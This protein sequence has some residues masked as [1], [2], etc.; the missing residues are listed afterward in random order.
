MTTWTS[1]HERP[2]RRP[3][4]EAGLAAFCEKPLAFDVVAAQRMVD[5]GRGCGGRE[6]GGVRCCGS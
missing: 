1:E 3:R 2:G 4:A 5:A 6:P